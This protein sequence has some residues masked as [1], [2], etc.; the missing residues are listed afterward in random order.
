MTDSFK[1]VKIKKTRGRCLRLLTNRGEFSIARDVFDRYRLKSGD[2]V[3]NDKMNRI[4]HQSGL[5][6]ARHYADYLLSGR[7]YSRGLLRARMIKKGYD[8][9]VID[10]II[11]ELTN[12][13]WLNDTNYAREAIQAMLRH[14]PAG[15]TY[16]VGWLQSKHIARELAE[17]LVEEAMADIDE[18]E[19]AMRI[20]RRR[21][22][23]F[24]KF[25][26]ETAR[27]KAYNYLSRRSISY[28][29]AKM[30][31]ERIIEDES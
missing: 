25:D 23:Y 18:G 19:L 7:N 20:L 24:S 4:L 27:R 1:V 28:G 31:F 3:G 22:R 8:P 13:G 5:S 2:I 6:S 21:W 12:Q 11:S 9:G 26:L 16:L 15:K 10:E 17:K 29:S 14:R 30:A